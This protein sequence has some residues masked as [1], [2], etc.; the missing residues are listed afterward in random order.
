VRYFVRGDPGEVV[1]WGEVRD[2]GGR[3]RVEVG[4]FATAALAR[5]AC[6]RDAQRRRRA[7]S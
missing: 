5:A 1:A 7:R 6:E 4:S 3:Y 2:P